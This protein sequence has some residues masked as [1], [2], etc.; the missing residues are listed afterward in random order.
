MRLLAR[1]RLRCDQLSRS[2]QR[3]NPS[4]APLRHSVSPQFEDRLIVYYL[5][6]L[7]EKAGIDFS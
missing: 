2:E 6:F 4:R 5:A 7:V 3:R 1:R